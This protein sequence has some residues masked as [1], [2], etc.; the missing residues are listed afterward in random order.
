MRRIGCIVTLIAL[1][2]SPAL[3]DTVLPGLVR[4]PLSLAIALPNG[5]QVKLE[6]LVIRPDRP[7]HFPLV[8]LIHGSPR[9]EP[10]K[11]LEAYRQVLP[12]V[13]AAPALQFAQRGF[14]AVTILRR[15]FGRSEGLYAEFI[16]D[17]CENT[18]YVRVARISAEDVAGA[19]AALRD[20]PWVDGNRVIMLGHSTG[21]LAVVAAGALN[22][23]GVVGILDFA[24]GRGSF[25]PDQVCSPD[26][27]VEAFD[28]FGRTA[29][30]PSLWIIAENDHYLGLPL[31]HRLFEAY[32]N[33]GAPA[34]LQVLPPFGADGHQLVSAGPA[35][36]WWPSV[37]PF[38]KTLHFD[39]SIV[40]DLP[41]MAALPAPTTPP[42]N[43]ACINFFNQYNSAR[44]DTKAFA[45]GPEGHCTSI[46][47]AL[48]RC[49]K[50]WKECT[51]YAVGQELVR[52]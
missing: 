31:S 51:L 37:E 15:G 26:R 9:S 17:P 4:E 38:L 3:A 30:I 40:V 48:D 29:R 18:D 34:Q 35:D 23:A 33:A 28:T 42:L 50:A 1:W 52:G 43:P 49:A 36:T 32:N 41:P 14:A 39:A 47:A 13:L 5:Q 24:G 44:S 10:G 45:V 22:P 25:R 7:G 20:E 11:F 12:D 21:G 2:T 46:L 27:L 6:G 8:V 16:P 19:V